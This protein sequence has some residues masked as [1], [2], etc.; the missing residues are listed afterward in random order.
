MTVCV[1]YVGVPPRCLLLFSYPLLPPLCSFVFSVTVFL[2][3]P[4]DLFVVVLHHISETPGVQQITPL[5]STALSLLTPWVIILFLV[6]LSMWTKKSPSLCDHFL[7]RFS[8]LD[9]LPLEANPWFSVFRLAIFSP[10]ILRMHCNPS[11]SPLLL[12]RCL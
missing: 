8:V 5:S 7:R 3:P 4:S 10:N 2:S 1:M 6:P 11:S 9:A 12:A